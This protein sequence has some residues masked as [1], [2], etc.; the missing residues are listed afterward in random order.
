MAFSCTPFSSSSGRVSSGIHLTRDTLY[1][2][3]IQSRISAKKGISPR[4]SSEQACRCFQM[5]RGTAWRTHRVP[6][7]SPVSEDGSGMWSSLL[8][9]LKVFLHLW[10]VRNSSLCVLARAWF[11][12]F[13]YKQHIH[14]VKAQPSKQLH[15]PHAFFFD[16][17]CLKYIFFWPPS[18]Q[19]SGLPPSD[20]GCRLLPL[21]QL[22]Q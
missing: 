11:T 22:L 18:Q 21:V 1:M 13:S 9:M 15:F 19:L 4:R 2:R 3:G 20:H 16:C 12:E 6:N 5:C 7:L 14:S 17:S 10:R 8:M